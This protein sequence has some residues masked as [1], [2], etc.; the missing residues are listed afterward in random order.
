MAV[1]SISRQ[2][3][4]GGHEIA[5][6]VAEQLGYQLFDQGLMAKIGFEAGL[7]QKGE[8]VDLTAEH[9]HTQGVMERAFTFAPTDTLAYG[10]YEA[11][12]EGAQDRSA[13]VVTKIINIAYR[14]GNI[15]IEGRGGQGVLR[16]KPDVLQVRVVAPVEQRVAALVKRDNCIVIEAQDKIK[17][18][19]ASQADYIMRY[20]GEVINDPTLYDIMINTS[21]ITVAAAAAAIVDTM[22]RIFPPAK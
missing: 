12:G 2:V 22:N 4:S 3:G 7:T 6:L 20:F 13:V 5:Q 18:A 11:S 16:G 1:I 19:D 10:A 15:V 9:H 14:Q 8:V 21:K 17:E